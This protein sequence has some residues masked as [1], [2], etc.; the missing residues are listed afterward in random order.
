[1]QHS[2]ESAQQPVHPSND[3][4]AAQPSDLFP[5]V[6]STSAIPTTSKTSSGAEQ[7]PDHRSDAEGTIAW[8]V[9]PASCGTMDEIKTTATFFICEQDEREKTT[10]WERDAKDWTG[11]VPPQPKD[12]Q[13]PGYTWYR[14]RDPDYG[15][16]WF[17]C[18]S[19]PNLW[20]YSSEV[21][22]DQDA[23]GN[24]F[25]L[26]QGTWQNVIDPPASSVSAEQP[27]DPIKVHRE[28]ATPA[29]ADSLLIHHVLLE[30]LE[31]QGWLVAPLLNGCRLTEL[32]RYCSQ[33]LEGWPR[34][35][36]SLQ[37]CDYLPR[38]V[39]YHTQ[40]VTN[41]RWVARSCPQL[42]HLVLPYASHICRN[43]FDITAA[44]KDIASGCPNLQTLEIGGHMISA[45]AIQ[46]VG[47]ACH[48]LKCLC[49]GG[50]SLTEAALCSVASGCPSL[51]KLDVSDNMITN[52]SIQMVAKCCGQLRDLCVAECTY[53][54]DAAIVSIASSCSQLQRLDVEDLH[55][56]TDAAIRAVAQG[57]PHL[58]RLIACRCKRLT[59]L[60]ISWL[61]QGC[62]QLQTLDVCECNMLTDHA[63]WCLAHD[64]TRLQWLYTQ[65]CD[66]ITWK[67]YAHLK[68]GCPEL[69]RWS[70]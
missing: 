12:M 65:F 10:L 60:A 56:L 45:A 68:Q 35:L 48:E 64:S 44:I 67:F 21:Q 37:Y 2:S 32:N 9:E 36:E 27:A 39:P 26:F 6:E 20:C 31:T 33:A 66:R 54:T 59:D 62:K 18:T 7:H 23:D 38:D 40:I 29:P 57:C 28:P 55:R 15:R 70:H 41:L 42:K 5:D 17:Y 24:I 3:S 34:R 46:T 61:T 16:T 63:I 53:L 4:G 43:D 19:V 8:R 22:N 49:M 1:M 14:Y 50:T 51:D 13:T 11:F 58:Q 52:A 30:C 47:Q 25:F 69:Q